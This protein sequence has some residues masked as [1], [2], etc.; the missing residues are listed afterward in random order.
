LTDRTKVVATTTDFLLA[1][2]RRDLLESAG[3]R[4]RIFGEHTAAELL[5]HAADIVEPTGPDVPQTDTWALFRALVGITP[6]R[7]P[8]ASATR[9]AR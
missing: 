3:I 1:H 4:A 7:R 2:L 9:T 6:V 8:A 5:D